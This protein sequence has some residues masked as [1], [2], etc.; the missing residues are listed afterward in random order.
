MGSNCDTGIGIE[1]CSFLRRLYR[2]Y[3]YSKCPLNADIFY[4]LSLEKHEVPHLPAWIDDITCC[5]EGPRDPLRRVA[6][7]QSKIVTKI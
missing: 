1:D 4:K 2:F 5:C 6:G 3:S 7:L